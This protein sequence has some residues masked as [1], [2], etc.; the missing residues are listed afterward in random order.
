[1]RLRI[2]IAALVTLILVALALRLWKQQEHP[3]RPRPHEGANFQDITFFS[4]SLRRPM[5]YRVVL[6]KDLP[7]GKALPTVYLL[8]GA[9]DFFQD[10]TTQSTIADL[11]G[12]G[13]I[14]ILPQGD[15]S[16][17]MNADGYPFAGR[18]ERYEDYITQDLIRDAEAKF[19]IAAGREKRAIAGVSMGGFGGLVLSMHHPELY[20]LVVALS[21][22][23]DVPRRRFTFR[24]WSQSMGYRRIFG[25]PGS[26]TRQAGDPFEL[27][28]HV[29]PAK[30]P[31]IFLS[32]GEQEPL[33]APIR[34]F[35]AAAKRQHLEIEVHSAPGEH[36]WSQWQTQM[37]W[38]MPVMKEWAGT[39]GA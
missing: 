31:P 37:T 19:P 30:M 2:L 8:H 28:R 32:F 18:S 12:A 33:A 26:S 13:M 1:M 9:G 20:S 3:D 6:P 14:L 7:P 15:N 38:L 23:V 10:W 21:P 35:A 29:D 5:R 25:A 34:Q 22:P 39:P 24:R 4:A 36:T 27:V 16:Y 17:Y 11:A